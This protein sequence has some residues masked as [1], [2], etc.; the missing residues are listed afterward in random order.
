MLARKFRLNRQEIEE[1]IK[2]G[3]SFNGFFFYIKALYISSRK[4]NGFSIIVSK[5]VEK[6]SVGRHRIKRTISSI[7]ENA[8]FY[9]KQLKFNSFVFILKQKEKDFFNETGLKKDIE[10]VIRKIV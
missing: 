8:L 4:D 6:T 5:K 10:D 1:T 9:K 3:I 2:K 7:I